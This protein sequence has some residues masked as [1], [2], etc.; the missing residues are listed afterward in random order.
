[1][2]LVKV[3]LCSL[4]DSVP[5]AYGEYMHFRV[6]TPNCLHYTMITQ[7]TANQKARNNT[8]TGIYALKVWTPRK[9][10]STQTDRP[11]AL[12]ETQ[13]SVFS[14]TLLKAKTGFKDF[15]V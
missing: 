8:L 7:G 13:H 6:G 14:Q 3:F 10:T 1:M 5:A 12:T 4:S 9:Q 11:V 15:R 2:Q